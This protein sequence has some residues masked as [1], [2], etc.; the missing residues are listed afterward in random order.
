MKI[1]IKEKI[2]TFTPENEQETADLDKLW[3]NVIDCN[4]FNKKLTP[5]GT[6]LPG[7]DAGARFA[8]ED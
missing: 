8:I 4:A 3:K 7:D 6:Y 1:T 2:V 5:M